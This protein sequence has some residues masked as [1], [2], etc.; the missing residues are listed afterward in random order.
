M[1]PF[2]FSSTT[3]AADAIATAAKA[4]TAQ[5]GA[6]VRFVAGGTTLVDLMKLDVERPLQVID[7]NHLPL[8]QVE[9]LPGGGLKIGALVRNSDLAHQ[10]RV[11]SLSC[12]P[13]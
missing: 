13:V 7:I 12:V 8:D 9:N 6:E 2:A 3:D 1:Q 5:Q 4:S 11:V 10:P